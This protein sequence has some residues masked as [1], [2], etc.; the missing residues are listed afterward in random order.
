MSDL[1]EFLR[2][3][4][5]DGAGRRLSDI[6]A[7]ND[8]ELERSHDYIQW[9]FPLAEA[10]A[11]NPAAPTLSADEIELIRKDQAIRANMRRSLDRMLGFF[12]FAWGG[13]R[14]ALVLS[15]YFPQQAA[16]WLSTGNHNFLRVTRILRSLNLVGEQDSARA[17]LAALEAIY[18]RGYSRVIGPRSLELWQQAIEP[19]RR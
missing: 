8:A 7:M 10:S 2:G 16:T 14:R 15:P 12:G 11:A 18:K 1:L 3:K 9:M 17:F 5:R 13:D 6:W 19:P 4:G